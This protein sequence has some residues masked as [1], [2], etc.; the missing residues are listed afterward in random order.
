MIKTKCFRQI[1]QKNFL[2]FILLL[3][4]CLFGYKGRYRIKKEV[5]KVVYYMT[6]SFKAHTELVFPLKK[7]ERDLQPQSLA[8]NDKYVFVAYPSDE[9]AD[10]LK[11]GVIQIYDWTGKI[12]K[13]IKGLNTGHASSISILN[14]SILLLLAKKRDVRL[15]GLYKKINY[16]R[17]TCTEYQ[18]PSSNNDMFVDAIGMD[19]QGGYLLQLNGGRIYHGRGMLPREHPTKFR[20]CYLDNT[21]NQSVT[22]RAIYINPME[23]YNVTQGTAVGDS[24]IYVLYLGPNRKNEN[25]L[26]WEKS[27]LLEIDAKGNQTER[28]FPDYI[29]G[30]LEGLT[31]HDGNLYSVEK[32]KGLVKLV[33]KY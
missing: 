9:A 11:G 3:F 24:R 8:T 1:K 28:N 18:I 30:E 15:G 19:S 10:T 32:N 22:K 12:I 21:G 14:D 5:N 27:T 6:D 2:L 7:V 29:C 4:L 23:Y 25:T 17:N 16:I 26:F 20:I 31:Y 13:E 33:Y